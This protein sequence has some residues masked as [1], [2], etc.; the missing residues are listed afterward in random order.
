M[1]KDWIEGTSAQQIDW[2]SIDPDFRLFIFFRTF[3]LHSWQ[4]CVDF[5]RSVS[6]HT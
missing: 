2:L 5:H 3:G 4:V 6:R 1:T